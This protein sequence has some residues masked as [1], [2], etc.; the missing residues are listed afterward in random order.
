MND[1]RDTGRPETDTMSA[2]AAA[3]GVGRTVPRRALVRRVSLV[4][5][6]ALSVSSFSLLAAVLSF[7]G[8]L[9]PLLARFDGAAL[10]LGLLVLTGLMAVAPLIFLGMVWLAVARERRQAEA[11]SLLRD[12]REA[13][14]ISRDQ[15][16][17][18]FDS[19]PVPYVLAGLDGRAVQANAQALG[20]F[21]IDPEA[22]SDI[23][24]FDL[25]ADP[26]FS[27]E[28]KG[29]LADNGRIENFEITM[30]TVAGRKCWVLFSGARVVMEGKP[31]MF[32]AFA[33]ITE[34]K[35][36]EQALQKNEAALRAII[37]ASP[38]PVILTGHASGMV[39]YVNQAAAKFF[40]RPIKELVG[41]PAADYWES[42][43]QYA[44]LL[45]E[46]NTRGHIDDR[47]ARM[48]RPDGDIRWVQGATTILRL[49]EDTLIYTAFSDITER[50]RKESELHRLATTD[51][52]TG[53]MNRRAFTER[54]AMEAGRARRN[55]SAVALVICDLDHFKRINDS[56]GHAT[57]DTVL[58]VFT[59][60][61]QE[62]IR[63][64]DALGRIGGEE[65]ALLLP[66][67]DAENGA[68]VAER[69]RA[70][71][72]ATPIAAEGGGFTASASFGVA[73]WAEG[74]PLEKAFSTADEAL[75]AAKAKGRNRVEI[76][77]RG[78]VVR[79]L[80]T[81]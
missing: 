63:P 46:L 35:R 23:N 41:V 27:E 56:Y 67:S 12:N 8:G 77:G 20:L 72:A 19:L 9:S 52:L 61:V 53:A 16:R 50:K 6:L 70:R 7:D 31:M 18:V 74:Q 79:I 48:Q 51:P 40:G 11:L 36:I 44:A 73:L 54:C 59:G 28:L 29:Y 76:A 21:G 10:R 30:N 24:V 32:A 4:L 3:S 45:A 75:Y 55:G 66:G 42:P 26:A 15:M 62:M 65:F 80:P 58:K 78:E 34:R 43:H 60:I 25:Y 47:E 71:F 17:R 14:R 68:M 49:Q 38:I 22:L 1:M 69:V 33:D 13:L 37:D 5:A 64:S 39:A 81:A 2:A 57:G